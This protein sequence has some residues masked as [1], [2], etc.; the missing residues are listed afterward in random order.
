M[1]KQDLKG[2]VRITTNTIHKDIF[3]PFSNIRANSS[4]GTGF[5]V[6]KIHILTCYHV[7]AD[8][9]NIYITFPYKS[10][11]KYIVDLIS[12]CP[13]C[14]VAL[15]RINKPIVSSILCLGES[16]KIIK[17]SIAIALG[18]PLG[19]DN[20]K[21]TKGTISGYDNHFF[22]TDTTINPGNSGGPLVDKD[23]QVIGINTQKIVS[24]NV[25]NTGFSLP[26]QIALD[27]FFSDGKVQLDNIQLIKKK[28]N[29]LLDYYYSTK[30]YY[31]I[32]QIKQNQGVVINILM[33]ESLL[34][35]HGIRIGDIL[36]SIDDLLIDSFG[37]I[38]VNWSFDKVNLST[39]LIRKNI[40]D[41]IKIDY[42]SASESITKSIV[43]KIDDVKYGIKTYYHIL[44]KTYKYDILGGAIICELTTNHLAEV[45]S[46][47]HINGNNTYNLLK[48]NK[49]KY[50]LQPVLFI[51]S[52]LPG[53]YVDKLETL[54]NG[55]II[56]HI[57]HKSVKTIT[58]VYNVIQEY[59][60]DSFII[61]KTS[62]NKLIILNIKTLIEK[63]QQIA[64][65]YNYKLGKIYKILSS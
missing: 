18:Y 33:K 58:D 34:Y 56:T 4:T 52:I 11:D 49:L 3:K 15:L 63:E 1:E 50:K 28:P 45:I 7:V 2:V 27:L 32:Q 38:S 22:Q 20:L 8:A 41:T 48:Y 62:N 54:E 29:L 64:N 55:D 40:G 19:T 6:D 61:L 21:I 5:F 14:D 59:S 30:E 47:P 10:K 9:I 39:Y 31:N 65:E 57:N 51:S 16:D 12:F 43:F 23:Y 36:L 25:D 26:L 42:F 44:D 60:K 35:L 37:D 13:D 46:A 53:S 17:G 24:K